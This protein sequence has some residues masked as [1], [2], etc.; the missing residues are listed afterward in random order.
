ML[1]TSLG[2]L[3]VLSLTFCFIQGT[4]NIY[5]GSGTLGGINVSTSVG[6][7]VALYSTFSIVS[8]FAGSAHNG[9]GPRVCIIIGGITYMIYVASLWY[10]LY[11][12]NTFLSIIG[13]SMVG[14]GA[15][16]SWGAANTILM[17]YPMEN[18]KGRFFGIFWI[19]FNLGS[20]IGGFLPLMQ[21]ELNYVTIGF[22]CLMLVGVS[23]AWLLVP[24]ALVIRENST[25]V[26]DPCRFNL[27]DE[28]YQIYNSFRC[29]YLL[30]LFPL[31]F[32]SNFF[33]A[34]RL[35]HLIHDS[36]TDRTHM[37]NTVT[38]WAAQMLGAF[39]FGQ[40]L[41]CSLITRSKRGNLNRSH[42]LTAPTDLVDSNY[43]SALVLMLLCGFA[44][45]IVQS[46]CCWILG[47]KTNN[48]SIL[49][50]Y[51]GIYK[52]VQSAGAATAWFISTTSIP[53]WLVIVINFSLFCIALLLAYFV[54]RGIT[55]T[56]YHLVLGSHD[57]D[58]IAPM[59]TRKSRN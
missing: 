25:Y 57:E 59:N 52:A 36:F 11:T 21:V 30:L 23:V 2:Q 35:G 40:F 47:A 27:F 19:L 58:L 48:A 15:S 4:Y 16:L 10:Y 9:L 39:T 12:G 33:Y 17:A 13:A 7:N 44:D 28:L 37:F 18:Q 51:G 8:V 1:K 46:Y 55:N 5:Y 14:F 41:D 3:I 38:Y 32:Y 50:R 54:A 43:S 45:A 29:Q 24:P 49:S 26:S 31:F 20:L 22:L 53:S 42:G 34:Y 56:N 6:N